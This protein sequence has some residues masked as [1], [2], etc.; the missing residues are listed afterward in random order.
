MQEI[1][2]IRYLPHRRYPDFSYHI[3]PLGIRFGDKLGAFAEVG[4]GVNGFLTCGINYRM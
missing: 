3:K 2:E 4:S 1:M